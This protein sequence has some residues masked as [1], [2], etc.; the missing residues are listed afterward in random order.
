MHPLSPL[1]TSPTKIKSFSDILARA[2]G[3]KVRKKG[4]SY[5]GLKDFE[6]RYLVDD[7]AIE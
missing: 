6:K 7:E 2:S 1:V 5:S 3:K 4:K